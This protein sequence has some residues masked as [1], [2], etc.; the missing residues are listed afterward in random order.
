MAV[1]RSTSSAL[2]LSRQPLV[3][4][5]R[6]VPSCAATSSQKASISRR[7]AYREVM[8]RPSPSEWVRDCEDEKPSPPAS[9]DSAKS[10]RMAAISSSVAT[11]SPRGAPMTLRRSAQW[12]TRNPA[13]T[14]RRP[15]RASRYSAKL[16]QFQGTPFSRA[17]R[18]MPST[19]AIICRM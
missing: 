9:N 15:S 2:K 5:S 3:M 14:P 19:L 1:M 10:A 11:S 8:G 12:P 6:V 18:G 4:Y 17:A 16:D 7:S 13:L